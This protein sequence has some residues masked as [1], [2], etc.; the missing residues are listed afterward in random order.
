VSKH[1]GLFKL[2]IGFYDG[3]CPVIHFKSNILSLYSYCSSVW[4]TLYGT[5]FPDE[6]KLTSSFIMGSFIY[7][8]CKL[9]LGDTFNVNMEFNAMQRERVP[10]SVERTTN[11]T[12]ALL[13]SS[14]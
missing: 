6:Y 10:N 1:L 13:C 8:I 2:K 9:S 4:G 11:Y 7:S 12:P 3:E 14:T 5:P